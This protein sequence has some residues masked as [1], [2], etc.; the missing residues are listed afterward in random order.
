M[1]LQNILLNG[2]YGQSILNHYQKHGS[3]N[4]KMRILLVD[5][6]L[7][8]CISNDITHVSKG[9]CLQLANEIVSTFKNE[10][11]V[12]YS[13]IYVFVMSFFVYISPPYWY[14]IIIVI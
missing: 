11:P 3:L 14:I 10:I 6:F 9:E 8:H 5:A 12:K 4:D 13:Y 7:Q 1:N 2:P